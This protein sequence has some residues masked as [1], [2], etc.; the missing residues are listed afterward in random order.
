LA[1]LESSEAALAPK[2]VPRLC[3]GCLATLPA[4]YV[5]ERHIVSVKRE[6]SRLPHFEW[7][8]WEERPGPRRLMR[9][10]LA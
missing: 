5:G 9:M 10:L 6:P 2:P 3:Y 8:Q 4:D 1:R 7:C